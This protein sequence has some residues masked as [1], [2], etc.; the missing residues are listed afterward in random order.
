[1]YVPAWKSLVF[2]VSFILSESR[3][4]KHEMGT[5]STGVTWWVTEITLP[6]TTP[7][8]ETV[9]CKTHLFA[10]VL[11]GYKLKCCGAPTCE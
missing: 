11:L 7:P 5:K 9:G 4:I 10:Q 1:M 8:L 2:F 6:F 3:K